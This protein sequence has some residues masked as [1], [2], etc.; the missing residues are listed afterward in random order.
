[1]DREQLIQRL[2]H[3]QL[4]KLDSHKYSHRLLRVLEDGFRGFAEMSD[5]E[6]A[7][8]LSRR[9]LDGELDGAEPAD[10]PAVAD[11]DEEDGDIRSLLGDMRNHDD[12]WAP[13]PG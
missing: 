9:G 5:E 11:E 6:L 3:D 4:E 8:E 10:E 2:I 13:I 1:M 7:E 12:D